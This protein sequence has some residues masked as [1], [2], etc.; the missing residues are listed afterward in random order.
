MPPAKPSSSLIPLLPHLLHHF[1]HITGAK[2]L[3]HAALEAWPSPPV[4]PP[5]PGMLLARSNSPSFRSSQGTRRK[6][7]ASLSCRVSRWCRCRRAG[8]GRGRSVPLRCATAGNA[9]PWLRPGRFFPACASLRGPASPRLRLGA[10]KDRFAARFRHVRSQNRPSGRAQRA[11][12]HVAQGEFPASARKI[13]LRSRRRSLTMLPLE[14]YH[15]HSQNR[16]KIERRSRPG[17][18]C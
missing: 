17:T 11:G 8:A 18:S 16:R 14:P 1:H 3:Q 12:S 7:Q 5:D 2:P 10:A 6:R 15:A 4:S 9:E 13:H